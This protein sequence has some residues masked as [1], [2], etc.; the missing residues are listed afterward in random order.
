[1][2]IIP[3]ID[4]VGGKCVRLQQ[5][6]AE[7]LTKYSDSPVTIAKKWENE[8]AGFLHIVDLDGAFKGS[9]VHFDLVVEILKQINIPIEIGGGIRDLDTIENYLAAG[10]KRVVLGTS[11]CEDRAFIENIKEA[12]PGK[13]IISVDVKD[14]FVVKR[15]WLE[16][17]SLKAPDFVKLIKKMG[18]DEVIYTD[19]S[20]DGMLVGPNIEGCRKIITENNIKVIASGGIGTLADI[21]KL[22]GLSKIGLKGVIIGKALYD[23][24]FSLREALEIADAC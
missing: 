5:G 12:F 17:S 4:I 15:G 14:G 9:P 11:A 19:I 21:R 10:A 18:F 13:V 1:M 7:K 6:R 23:E 24:R 20:K 2:I 3:A 22:S 8:G 16:K